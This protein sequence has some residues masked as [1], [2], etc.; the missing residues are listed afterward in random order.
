[1]IAA[2]NRADSLDPALL[3]P[4]RFDRRL[5]FE[6]PDKA[7]RR[8]LVDHFLAGKSHD[9]V[10]DEPQR[11]DALAGMTQGYTPAML[12][13]LMDEALVNAVRRKATAMSWLDLEHARLATEVGIGLPVGYTDHEERLIATHEAGHAVLAW[14]V[15]PHRRLEVLTIIKRAGSLGLLAHGDR[16]DVYTRSRRELES[17]MCIAFGGQAAEDLFF[18]DVSTGPGGD[19][20]YAT[21]VAAQMVGQAGM[22]DTLISFS[23]VQGSALSDQGLV[24]RVL[25]DAQGPGHG[26]E[27]ARA[28][29]GPRRRP[30]GRQ[31]APRRGAAGRPGGPSRAGGRRDHR[32]PRGR[33]GRPGG[34]GGPGGPGRPGGRAA[35]EV[36]GARTRGRRRRRSTFATVTVYRPNRPGGQSPTSPGG[37]RRVALPQP[38]TPSALRWSRGRPA[39]GWGG[40][41]SH[42]T[43]VVFDPRTRAGCVVGDTRRRAWSTGAP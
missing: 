30:A 35:Q 40:A 27:P 1:M 16:E 41:R 31:P 25:G 4:G 15:A 32:H 11:R 20:T 14:L 22:A 17:L 36:V 10:L 13:R 6:A 38:S 19:L 43:E 5:A 2:T 37:R 21:N 34:S 24:G 9:S 28:A 33:P 42:E 3:R 8:E 18:G 23:A 39:W 29:A 7:G 26:R 12:E